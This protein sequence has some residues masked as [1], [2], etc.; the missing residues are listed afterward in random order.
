MEATD[1]SVRPAAFAV[2]VKHDVVEPQLPIGVRQIGGIVER[3]LRDV[4]GPVGE[5]RTTAK[6]SADVVERVKYDAGDQ[7]RLASGVDRASC[8]LQ[9][10][11]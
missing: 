1:Q 6:R 4:V 8:A 7:R 5:R 2:A 10:S 3:E 11:N 9:I